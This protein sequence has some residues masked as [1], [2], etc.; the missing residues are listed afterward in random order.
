MSEEQAISPLEQV[1]LDTIQKSSAVTGEIYDGA[2]KV[3]GKAIDFA[4]EQIPDVIHQLL[5][6]KFAH[7][8]L[9]FFVFLILTGLLIYAT[10]KIIIIE[11]NSKYDG[12]QIFALFSGAGSI[13]CFFGVLGNLTWLKIWIAPKVYLLEYAA[14]L[15]RRVN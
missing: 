5:M 4:V 3:T 13:G 6:W 12:A 14:E 9:Y 1:L 15:V 8:L 2:K 11:N 7:S 10:Y